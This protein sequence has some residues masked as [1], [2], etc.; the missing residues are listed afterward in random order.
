MRTRP[1]GSQDTPSPPE[2]LEQFLKRVLWEHSNACDSLA[3]DPVHDLRVAL[4]RCRTLAE[5]FATLDDSPDWRRMR[6][7][8]KK[9]QA[10]LAGL[11]DAQVM[12]GEVRQFHLNRGAA[13]RVLAE[14]IERDERRA[15]RKAK[16]A[17]AWLAMIKENGHAEGRFYL[18]FDAM[19]RPG[20]MA[21]ITAALG[22]RGI[23][24]SGVLQHERDE[25][26]F[27]PVVVLTHESRRGDLLDAVERI[28]AM[29]CI[30]GEPVVI[31]IIDLPNG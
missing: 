29:D 11:R 28:K 24:L 3:P 8:A 26:R 15:E 22:E 6:K 20:T 1:A 5:G 10:G 13:G 25:D 31:R 18:R 21:Q 16:Q 17:L 23:S 14:S 2:A 9:L 19:D 4:R 27:V 7:V 30:Q 12:A